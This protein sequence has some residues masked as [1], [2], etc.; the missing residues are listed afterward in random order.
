MPYS[1]LIVVFMA[2]SLTENSLHFHLS[3][4]T[5]AIIAIAAVLGCGFL[6]LLIVFFV[7]LCCWRW[8]KKICSAKVSSENP[9]R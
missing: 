1:F 7:A 3:L 4:G 2:N 6:A 5:G 9:G 8:R